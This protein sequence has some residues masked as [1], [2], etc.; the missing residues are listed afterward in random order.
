MDL[1]RQSRVNFN[2]CKS[3]EGE[4]GFRVDAERGDGRDGDEDSERGRGGGDSD[5]EREP[6]LHQ[7]KARNVLQ[8]HRVLASYR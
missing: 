1:D 7:I 4:S 3:D 5:S 2:T 6:R 8:T